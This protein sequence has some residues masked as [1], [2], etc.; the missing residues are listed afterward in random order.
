MDKFWAFY[1]GSFLL[2]LALEHLW[3]V[4]FIFA[5][6]VTY[7]SQAKKKVYDGEIQYKNHGV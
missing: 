6:K 3:N 2:Y 7:F 5:I 4:T 1:L